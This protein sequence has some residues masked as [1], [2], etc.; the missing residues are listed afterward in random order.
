[1]F[2][3]FAQQ[4]TEFALHRCWRYF[5]VPWTGMSLFCDGV[6]AVCSHSFL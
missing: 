6:T 2:S 4:T 1:M 5:S 3:A